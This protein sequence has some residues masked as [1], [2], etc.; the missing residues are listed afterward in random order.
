MR[1]PAK[2]PK[3]Q[4]RTL[5]KKPAFLA[6]YIACADLTRAAKAAK[7]DRGQHYDWLKSDKKYAAAFEAAREQAG[8]TLEDDAVHWARIGTF[9]QYVYQGRPQFAQR[10][11]VKC[12]LPDKRE[13]Y[14][15]EFTIEELAAME[16]QSERT[17]T[18][19]DPRRPLGAFRRSEGLMGR[20]LKAF[21]PARY[22]ERSEVTGKDGGAIETAM[23]ITF[24]RPKP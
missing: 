22:A 16:V 12:L 17:V 8:Q 13:V 1:K 4:T 21:M 14:A 10:D 6:A 20:L 15:D 19:D 9:E 23:T 7:I 2:R 18:E 11:R 3:P 5:D 24:V